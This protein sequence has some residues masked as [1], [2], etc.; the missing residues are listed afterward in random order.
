MVRRLVFSLLFMLACLLPAFASNMQVTLPI[1]V[2]ANDGGTG[3]ASY[4]AGDTLY[5]SGST[6]ISKLT[7]G[8]NGA[9]MYSN[10]TAPQWAFPSALS[11]P[12]Q[13]G[14]LTNHGVVIGQSASTISTTAVGATGTVLTG[15]TGADPTFTSAPASTSLTL[16]GAATNALDFTSVGG[17]VRYKEGA[18]A[19]QGV[20]TLVAGTVT[21][22]NTSVTANSRIFV[23]PQNNSGTPGAVYV[24]AKTASTSFVITSTSNTDTRDVAWQITEGN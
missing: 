5:A 18:N 3:I 19:R 7:L 21:V 16:S 13:T 11:I 12:T 20:S 23:T 15:N 2:P 10:G 17:G 1:P 22:S 4:A 14:S 6:T 8:S 9:L 24:S